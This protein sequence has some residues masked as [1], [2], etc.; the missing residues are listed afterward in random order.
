MVV[1]VLP[2][3]CKW[4]FTESSQGSLGL[5]SHPLLPRRPRKVQFPAR[6]PVRAVGSASDFLLLLANTE[7]LVSGQE[8]FSSG[9]ETYSYPC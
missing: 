1:P 9:G 5:A 8:G 3:W 6:S 7:H 4:D 2:A